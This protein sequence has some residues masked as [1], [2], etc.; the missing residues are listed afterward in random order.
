MQFSKNRFP[1]ACA[2]LLT[3]VWA[4]P[5]T[6]TLPP[7][8]D[9]LTVQT[10]PALPAGIER[11]TTVEGITE[12]RMPANGLRILLFPDQSKETITVNI[13]YMV[14]SRHENYGET[15]MAHLLEHMVFKGTPKHP[16]IPQELTEHGTRPNGTTWLD[17]TNYYETFQATE[18]NLKWALD[19]E[20]D[21]MVNSFIAKKDLDSEMTVVRNEFESGENSP[22]GVI[23][24]RLQATA[25]MWHNYGNSTIGAREDLENVP[26]E[27]LQAFYRTYYQPDNAV[28]MVAGKINEARTLELINEYFSKIPK[29]TRQL[30]KTYTL[31][32]VQDGERMVTVRRVG[33][34]QVAAAAY[35]V[36]ASSHED[37]AALS[38][39][40][41]ILGD[42]P[43]GRLHKGLVDSKKAAF[44][45]AF[46]LQ[47]KEP[48]LLIFGAFCPKEQA[49]TEVQNILLSTVEETAA[50]PI[51]EEEVSRSKTKLLKG[52]ELAASSSENLAKGLS[53]WIGNGDWRLY[54]LHRD[55]IKDVKLADVQRVANTYLV[56]SN[57]TLGLFI[58]TDKPVRAEI[59]PVP[60][61]AK[62]VENYK[63]SET[64]AEGEAFDPAP[65][66]IDARTIRT[67]KG[68]LKLT[69]L[70][71]KTRGNTVIYNLSLRIGSEKSLL[72]RSQAGSF[73]GDLLM[74]GTAKHTR[75]Q[76]QLELDKLKASMF[77]GGGATAIGGSIL[78]KRETLPEVLKLMAEVLKEPAFSAEEFEKLKKETLTGLEQGRSEPET[79]ASLE[80]SRYLSPYKKGHPSYVGTIDEEI[81]EIKALKLEDVKK[82]YADFYGATTGEITVIG[83]FDPKEIEPLTTQLLGS[84]KGKIP[85]ERIPE[86]FFAPQPLNK[87]FETPDKANANF[88][89]AQPLNISD[90]D[91]DYPALVLGNYILGGGFLNSRLAV[92]IRQKEGISYDVG[93]FVFAS[94]LDKTGSFGATAIYAP[95]NVK[96]LEAAF[97]EEI[98]RALKDGFTAEEVAAAKS[99]YLQSR[100]VSRSQDRELAGRLSNYAFLNR[101]MA[102]DVDF[103]AKINALTPEQILAAMRK[104]IDPAKI[105]IIKAGDF[106]KSAAKPA[107][108]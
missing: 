101:T 75:E 67:T 54:F 33:D 8:A 35:H 10:A 47:Q 11:V 106:A 78:A 36:P 81:A 89:A 19:L 15:G 102:W 5:V 6:S 107:A 4:G 76:L 74:R 60:D 83:D 86:Q 52:Y 94:S 55:R 3:S 96:R 71:K 82:F 103:E 57:R 69:F 16:N 70:P 46:P 79:I 39:L 87:S 37:F 14:G 2:L 68:G 23:L 25:F 40:A 7:V 21:R 13:T 17:R 97:L 9:K 43:S 44:A 31:D 59:P 104:H 93:S 41:T 61:V 45:L 90:G 58:P 51:T 72:N 99:G 73:A 65:A 62:L 105:T 27:R 20:A 50:T 22:F 95:E 80:L 42:T 84:W 28:L 100:K 53:D 56:S 30:Q 66:N 108:K 24:K 63:G 91:P 85:Y 48:G 98:R 92:R 26:I 38:V 1:L 64:I 49:L 88:E 12:Y 18:D 34:A 29:P 77:I 32:P